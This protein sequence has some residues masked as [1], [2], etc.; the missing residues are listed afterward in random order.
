MKKKMLALL[1]AMVMVLSLVPVTAFAT[2]VVASGRD[3]RVD[4]VLTDDGTLTISGDTYMQD[5][6]FEL[7]SP[8]RK[9]MD[10]VTSIVIE[11]GV[12]GVERF[13]FTEFENVTELS[14]PETLETIGMSAFAGCNSLKRVDLPAAVRKIDD[15]AFASCTSLTTLDVAQDN[16]YFSD[17]DGV[18]M[19]KNQ[20]TLIQVPAGTAGVY[21]VPDFVKTV[22]K[23]AFMGC[24]KLTSVSFPDH[25]TELP[26]AVLYNLASLTSV[27]LPAALT[28]IPEAAFY[29]TPLTTVE[30]PSQ[31]SDIGF[32]AF[33][34][35]FAL[36]N[37]V[38]T[39]NA[40]AINEYAFQLDTLTAWYPAGND[41]WTEEVMQDYAGTITWKS[42]EPLDFTDVPL[43]S[44]YYD[45]VLWAVK[46]NITSGATATT[47]NPNGECLRAQVVTFLWRAA[48]CPMPTD[49]DNPFEDVT[50]GDYYYNAVLW[51]VEQGITA[52]VDA[53]H[54]APMQSCSRA[55]VVAFLYRAM[56]SPKVSDVECPFTDVVAGEWYE[57]PV[58]WAVENGITAGLSANTFGVNT[59][60][61]RAQV[62]TF[63]YRTYVN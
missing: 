14:L 50:E 20:E 43:G 1:L 2:E 56:G 47:F 30:I 53:T 4:W 28:A 42:Y 9:Y 49:A 61:N 25:L 59:V 63:L 60:C 18:L 62:V 34:G 38:F 21:A 52:G 10:E 5:D 57:L 37:V 58:L 48:G 6:K 46:E 40:P 54:F 3:W 8:W 15:M 17:V 24:N 16:A 32:G 12:Y 39:G 26:N 22:R 29:G 27:R 31:V 36:K 55:Q 13:A 41:T 19:D 11:E 23:S 51:A 33:E 35:C 7:N 45:P 44:F